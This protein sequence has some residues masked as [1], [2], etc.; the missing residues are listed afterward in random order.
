M[1]PYKKCI[2]PLLITALNE[3]DGDLLAKKEEKNY[4]ILLSLL[5]EPSFYRYILTRKLN[6]NKMEVSHR[7]QLDHHR[8]LFNKMEVSHRHQLDHHR[9]LFNKMEVS[10]RNQ[11]DHH[12]LLFNKMEVS[13]RNQLDHHRLLFNKM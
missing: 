7:N 12:R 3:L 4:V 2:R 6:F 13:H 1:E 11:L 5:R 9:L 10:H 8:L